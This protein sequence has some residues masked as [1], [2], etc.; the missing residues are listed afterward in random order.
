VWNEAN[1]KIWT[2]LTVLSEAIGKFPAL[3]ESDS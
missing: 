1:T 3:F 2:R